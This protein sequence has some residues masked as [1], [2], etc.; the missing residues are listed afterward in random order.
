[1]R[2]TWAPQLAVLV[3]VLAVLVVRHRREL[4][5]S[6]PVPRDLPSYDRVLLWLAASVVVLIGPAVVV[7][8]PTWVVAL[9]AAVA[10]VAGFAV[11]RPH[12]VRVSR[13]VRLV[14]WSVLLFAV[15]LFA[16]VEL[17]V[18]HS[19]G[20]LRSALGAGDSLASLARLAGQSL[21]LANLTNNLR[22]TSSWSRSPSRPTAS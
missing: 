11:R 15:A 19:S 7:G 21:G 16:M 18:E 9:A 10:L 2:E 14:P 22:R 12:V 5:G 20:L 13:L 1:V 8:V 6:H 17:V 3:V 4:R